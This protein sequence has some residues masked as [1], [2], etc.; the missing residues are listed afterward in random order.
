MKPETDNNITAVP[1]GA[2]QGQSCSASSAQRRLGLFLMGFG[3]A[4]AAIAALCCMAPLLL[5]GIFAAVGFGLLLNDFVLMGLL[6]LFLVT[7]ASGFRM[8]RGGRPR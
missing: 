1:T 6:V 2:A 4:G 8:L 7:A 3:F 5:A